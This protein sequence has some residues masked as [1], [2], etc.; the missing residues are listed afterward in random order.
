MTLN[1]IIKKYYLSLN[2]IIIYK[3]NIFLLIC[4]SF[5]FS[6]FLIKRDILVTY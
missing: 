1:Y 5:K 2:I 6:I 4:L 3:T